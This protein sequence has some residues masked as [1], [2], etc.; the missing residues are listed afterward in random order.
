MFS[1]PFVFPC[2]LVEGLKGQPTLVTL[3]N[4]PLVHGHL[5][6]VERTQWISLIKWSASG[7]TC[8][9][10]IE[11]KIWWEE[12]RNWINFEEKEGRLCLIRIAQIW[13]TCQGHRKEE[14][15]GLV[16]LYHMLKQF[17]LQARLQCP[18]EHTEKE[19]HTIILKMDKESHPLSLNKECHH[20]I[21]AFKLFCRNTFGRLHLLVHANT[22]LTHHTM[23]V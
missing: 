17:P 10:C 19:L 7:N 20:I 21:H 8:S 6:G 13:Q 18:W 15:M 11:K 4:N 16:P 14:K 22:R 9:T 2:R 23:V 12:G 3:S 5:K 1:Y